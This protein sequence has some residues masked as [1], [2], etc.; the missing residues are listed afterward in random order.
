MK[1]ITRLD[2]SLAAKDRCL[3]WV[4]AMTPNIVEAVLDVA[5]ED[6][7]A[8]VLGLDRRCLGSGS[9]LDAALPGMRT[10]ALVERVRRRDFSGYV[11]I[12]REDVGPRLGGAHP[13]EA[14]R[15]AK[16]AISADIDAGLDLIH[17]DTSRDEHGSSVDEERMHADQIALY[18]HA[19][20]EAAQCDH[21]LALSIGSRQQSASDDS[22]DGFAGYVDRSITAILS[23][24]HDI[25]R[26]FS[27]KVGTCAR[28]LANHGRL[29]RAQSGSQG[30]TAHEATVSEASA[31]C[32]FAGSSLLAF[33]GDWLSAAAL[34]MMHP[35]GV[36]TLSMGISLAVEE[37]RFH[38]RLAESL[39]LNSL[40]DR[41][42]EVAVT[43]GAWRRFATVKKKLDDEEKCLLGG[44]LLLGNPEFS[45]LIGR[46]ER[47]TAAAGMLF[48]EAI[49]ESH[50]R[51]LRRVMHELGA[52]ELR[53]HAA[54]VEELVP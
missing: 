39:G 27:A 24:G 33:E 30:V 16:V 28:D 31:V 10:A 15:L 52:V 38:L 51:E 53:D 2:R 18:T 44:A 9:A 49:Q 50:R 20:A 47:R 35:L 32:E 54:P 12:A 17:I 43:S 19:A 6:R 11:T 26:H 22:L 8:M 1:P 34:R 23:H 48:S 45:G 13:A 29:M 41:I 40:R 4:T 36:E 3:L 46:L 42:V 7:Q 14:L 21:D 25:P 37:M 5:T